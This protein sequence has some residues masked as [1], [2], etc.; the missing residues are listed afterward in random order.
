MLP[1]HSSLEGYEHLGQ[2]Q[3]KLESPRVDP[4][5]A[6]RRPFLRPRSPQVQRD[7][8]ALDP[9]RDCQRI[10]N[11]LATYEFP[12]DLQRALE[13]A[14]FHTYGS[15][16]VSR[17]LDRTGEFSKRGQKRYDDTR[18][19]LTHFTES[20]WDLEMGARAIAQMNHIHSFFKI[21]NDDY[22]FVL[23]TFIDFPIQ[24]MRDF[25]WRPLTEHESQAWFSFWCELGRRMR[26][27][28]V[29][30]SKPA[31]DEFVRAY[32]AREFVANAAS[33]RVARAT[34]TILENWF[35]SPLRF[36]VA[37][38][39]LS[40]ARPQLLPAIGMSAPAPWVGRA[41]RGVLKLRAWVKRHVSLEH[42]PVRIEGT[43]NRTYPGNQ[44]TVERLGPEFAAR[45]PGGDDPGSVTR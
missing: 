45:R 42:S 11:L 2:K 25:G 28:D 34:L 26:L 10:V 41:V 18:L 27:S 16:S 35:P 5:T 17:L 12:F 36:A 20:G 43:P 32:E 38:A 15:Q 39:V 31:F 40:L 6:Y 9:V 13:V 4:E 3:S 44:Y 21:P 14:L 8:A 33:H 1:N 23:W 29:P 22:L 24:W 19:L 30:E 7:I 37:P